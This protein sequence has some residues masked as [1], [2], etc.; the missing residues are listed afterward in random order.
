MKNIEIDSIHKEPI[1]EVAYKQL[2]EA[3]LYG[4]LKT[5]VYYTENKFAELLN[6]SRTPVREAVKDLM[7]D[8]LLVAIPRRG[9]QVK[10]FTES[11]IEQIFLLRTTIENEVLIKFINTVTNEHLSYL[12]Q[13]LVE[14]KRAV[15][16]KDRIRFIE[17]DQRF[18][19]S[20]IRFVNYELI[21]E[22]IIKLHNLTRL[23]GHK[24]IMKEGRMEDVITEHGEIIQALEDKNI[25]KARENMTHHLENTKQSYKIMN[26]S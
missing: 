15:D 23:I 21:E 22:I 2:K 7:N 3:I 11:E 1:Y 16:K 19:L 24:A 26:E 20:I 9:L 6:I 13:L 12:K 14:Q 25:K 17:L 18:H 8:G 5:G 4:K 10:E